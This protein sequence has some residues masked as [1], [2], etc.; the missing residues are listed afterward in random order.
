[1]SLF[2][3]TVFKICGPLVSTA[4]KRRQT[5]V[6]ENG[7]GVNSTM[8]YCEHF[9]KCHNAPP[10]QKYGSKM[11]RFFHAGVSVKAKVLFCVWGVWHWD[12]N[13]GPHTY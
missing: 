5:G 7:G 13:S 6:K 3:V 1:M 4:N 11:H 8:I 2:H 10:E 12:L 9:C